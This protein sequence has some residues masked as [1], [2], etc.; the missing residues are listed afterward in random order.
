MDELQALR[1]VKDKLESAVWPSSSN[2]VFPSV[3][4]SA[5]PVETAIGN[6]L[7]LPCAVLIPGAGS[8]DPDFRNDAPGI[9]QSEFVVRLY[10]A[11]HGDDTGER[12]LLGA[13]RTSEIKSAGMGLLEI[14]RRLYAELAD[15]GPSDGIE[16][17]AYS[18]GPSI[19]ESIEGL[20]YL[21]SR[22]Y[23]F[24]AA[25]DTEAEYPPAMDL[26]G[27][28]IGGTQIAWSWKQPAARFDRISTVIMRYSAGST[29]PATSTDGVGLSPDTAVSHLQTGLS[30]GAHSVSIFQGYDE[31]TATPTNV[32]HVSAAV[33]RT[34]T[35]S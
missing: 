15:L 26:V 8:A 7:R 18:R 28:G 22:D 9:L 11:V 19:G 24:I 34:V 20:G 29:A 31:R 16:A 35:L 30:A 32:D 21:V 17:N 5:G 14:Q 27:T 4:I 10:T 2:V 6:R 12:P 1:Q 3:V 33:S 23:G 13:N 25:I